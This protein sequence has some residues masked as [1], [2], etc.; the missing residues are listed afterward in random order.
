MAETLL[1]LH[2]L[3]ILFLVVGFPVGLAFN[4]RRF[5]YFHCGVLALVTLLIELGIPC[6][7]TIMEELFRDAPHENSFLAF[8][9]SRII[10]LRWFEP[11]HVFILDMLFA[12]LVF[13]S[14]YWYPLKPGNEGKKEHLV[15]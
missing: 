13:S 10:Y 4:N 2:F 7:L 3:V 6:P 11:K 15:S 5:R 9:L 1:I 8:W 12:A 14:F